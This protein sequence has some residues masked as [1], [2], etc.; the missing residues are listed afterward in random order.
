MSSPFTIRVEAE[1]ESVVICLD[2]EDVAY[3]KPG[4]GTML[5]IAALVKAYEDE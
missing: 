2:G 1:S 3:C 4:T 5:L